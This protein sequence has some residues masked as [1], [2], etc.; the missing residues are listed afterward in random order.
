MNILMNN[1]VDADCVEMYEVGMNLGTYAGSLFSTLEVAT[2]IAEREYG[3]AV[4]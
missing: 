4:L 2:R 3:S 1:N